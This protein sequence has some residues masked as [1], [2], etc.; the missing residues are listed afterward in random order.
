MVHTLHRHCP[1]PSATR[2]RD[3]RD[4]PEPRLLHALPHNCERLLL[5]V[6]VGLA[7]R[8]QSFGVSAALVVAVNHGGSG[9]RLSCDWCDSLPC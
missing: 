1:D 4:E 7:V 2:S 3:H 5:P 6:V 8:V 9:S